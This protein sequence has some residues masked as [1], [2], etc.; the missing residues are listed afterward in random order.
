MHHSTSTTFPNLYQGYSAYHTHVIECGTGV[1]GHRCYY[2]DHVLGNVPGL[3]VSLGQLLPWGKIGLSDA[4]GQLITLAAIG[5]GLAKIAT[6]LLNDYAEY[7]AN[8]ER[9]PAGQK[10]PS[11]VPHTSEPVKG[12]GPTETE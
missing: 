10:S 7:R 9:T 6:D 3:W 11:P 2:L 1:W 5:I 12:A 8:N 4:T